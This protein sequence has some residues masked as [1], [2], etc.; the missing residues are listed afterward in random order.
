MLNN[1]QGNQQEATANVEKRGGSGWDQ[2]GGQEV[3]FW[4][5]FESIADKIFYQLGEEG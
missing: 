3:G 1:M 2:V 5:Y 4:I